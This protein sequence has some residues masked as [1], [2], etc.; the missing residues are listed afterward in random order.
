M[1]ES[2]IRSQQQPILS[3]LAPQAKRAPRIS[4]TYTNRAVQFQAARRTFA[5]T[6]QRRQDESS[7]G[8]GQGKPQTGP[9]LD[10]ELSSILDSSLDL[11]KGTPAAPTSRTSK[12]KSNSTQ[13]QNP[14]SRGIAQDSAHDMFQ[15]LMRD[16]PQKPNRSPNAHNVTNDSS[17]DF[18]DISRML[19][20]QN[21]TRRSAPKNNN[22]PP[23]PATPSIKLN[24]SV[25]RTVAVD[26]SRGMDVGRA[27]RTLDAAITRNQVRKHAR[28]QRFHERPGMKRKRLK[29]ERWRRRFKEGFRQ[30]VKRVQGMKAQ[31][32]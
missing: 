29:S 17:S 22:Q 25:G 21:N 1:G 10:S 12:F 16:P 13:P 31:G 27:F 28:L 5:T 3:F 30:M 32:W 8:D 24:A 7:K 11:K 18:D 2:L 6:P 4:R 15:E 14:P 23:A 20:P 19:N 26:S 9:S